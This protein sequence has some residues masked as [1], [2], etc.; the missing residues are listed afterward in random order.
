MEYIHIAADGNDRY[1]PTL[2]QKAGEHGK[3]F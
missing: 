1:N 2:G 3:V